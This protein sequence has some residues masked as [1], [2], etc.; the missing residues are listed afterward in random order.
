M[1]LLA[2]SSAVLMISSVYGMDVTVWANKDCHG[3]NSIRRWYA[4]PMECYKRGEFEVQ[5]QIDGIGGI[6]ELALAAAIT[7]SKDASQYV[8]F[9]TTDDCN[10]DSVIDNAWL[11]KGCSS[12]L[13]NAPTEYKSWSVWDMCANSEP[14]CSLE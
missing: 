10:P 6:K 13:P 2:T 5:L 11:D 3:F 7:D 4:K 8:V 9:F 1:H 12:K 14:E